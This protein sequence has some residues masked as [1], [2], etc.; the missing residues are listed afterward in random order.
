MKGFFQ[1]HSTDRQSGASKPVSKDSVFKLWVPSTRPET[2]R[3]RTA[4]SAN[5][6]AVDSGISARKH[7][8]GEEKYGSSRGYRPDLYFA[9]PTV[10]SSSNAPIASTSK[11]PHG[12]RPSAQ[13]TLAAQ[14]LPS[15]PQSQPKISQHAYDH[16]A[17]LQQRTATDSS[18]QSSL[19]R[20]SGSEDVAK[21]RHGRTQT[22]AVST[23]AAT[24]VPP[25][26]RSHEVPSSSRRHGERPD[27]VIDREREGHRH[28]DR[29]RT[30]DHHAHHRERDDGR[31][32]EKRRNERARDGKEGLDRDGRHREREKERE[33]LRDRAKE[34]ERM[35]REKERESERERE[36]VGERE[37]TREKDR[38]RRNENERNTLPR[39]HRY[40][41]PRALKDMD[42]AEGDS[43]D[44]ARRKYAMTGHRR[45]HTEEGTASTS[46]VRPSYLNIS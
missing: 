46:M 13:S 7:H 23:G 5:P 35:E 11:A 31:E 10:A 16:R 30:K 45:Y 36:R 27:G 39:E 14:P 34:R 43:S 12:S 44:S 21:A 22:P 26:V 40:K 41:V 38:D 20:V 28:R 33:S 24:T 1:R 2:E 17:Y 37:R 32:D 9:S 19:E 15:K 25:T 18:P 6:Q 3:I 29:D 42:D 4:P 8:A